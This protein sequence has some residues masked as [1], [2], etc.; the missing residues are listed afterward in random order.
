M[1]RACE[2]SHSVGAIVTVALLCLCASAPLCVAGPA[3]RPTSAPAA[4]AKPSLAYDHARDAIE[5]GK[6]DRVADLIDAGLDLNEATSDPLICVAVE[7]GRRDI[8]E[9]LLKHAA[10][11]DLLDHCGH[12]ALSHVGFGFRNAQNQA[13]VAEAL[14]KAGASVEPKGASAYPLTA[15][16]ASQQPELVK[17]LLAHGANPNAVA[18]DGTALH[19]AAYFDNVEIVQ[20]LLSAGANVNARGYG[21]RTPLHNAARAHRMTGRDNT[22]VIRLLVRSGADAS[23]LDED[24]RTPSQCGDVFAENAIRDAVAATKLPT[25]SPAATRPKGG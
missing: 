20:T 12:P 8:V 18:G 19:R 15:A 1:Q 17:L 2:K 3:T 13:A 25:T 21:E 5:R 16:V 7:E 24:G 11:P 22:E 4:P 10:N 14:L 23:A 9:L 6:A